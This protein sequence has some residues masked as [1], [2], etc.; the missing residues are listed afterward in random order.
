LL[1]AVG[2][3]GLWLCK[4]VWEH[5]GITERQFMETTIGGAAVWSLSACFVLGLLILFP[6]SLY[7]QKRAGVALPGPTA[8][9][10]IAWPLKLVMIL[11]VAL[12]LL[13]L[14]GVGVT[15]LLQR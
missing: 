8:P 15:S 13:I 11:G 10:W 5:Q 2:F 3:V 4:Q 1:T 7:L 9:G 6:I 14:I 12:L